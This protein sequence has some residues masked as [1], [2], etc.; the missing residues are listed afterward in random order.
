MPLAAVARLYDHRVDVELLCSVLVSLNT[1][2]TLGV[3][4]NGRTLRA[5]GN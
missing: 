5:D 1:C 3:V 4:R 2:R